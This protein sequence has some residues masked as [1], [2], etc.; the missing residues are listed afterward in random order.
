MTKL[1][2]VPSAII[3]D[4]DG[5][6][7][8]RGEGKLDRGPFDWDRVDED[9][10]NMPVVYL[11]QMCHKEGHR[12]LLVS[13]RHEVCREKTKDWC[14]YFGIPFGELFMR[15]HGDTRKDS[16]M[17]R[18]LFEKHIQDKYRIEFVLDDRNQV[19]AM[20][21]DELGLPCFQV[22]KGDF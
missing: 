8:L 4:I 7:A 21:R 14:R 13:G 18:E 20:W 19:V 6:L 12:I 17:K 9:L 15:A 22:A 1:N 5:T 11:V 10:P 2:W 16:I 3:C